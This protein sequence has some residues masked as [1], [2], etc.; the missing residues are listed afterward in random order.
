MTL[1]ELLNLLANNSDKIDVLWNFFIW[2]HLAVLGGLVLSNRPLTLLE[3]LIA[4]VAY[5]AFSFVNYHALQDTY[6]YH[7][8]LLAEIAGLKV[9]AATLGAQTVAYLRD[10]NMAGR[11]ALIMQYGHLAAGAVV[12][13]A[14]LSANL[15]T[16]ARR[17]TV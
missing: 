15:I 5:A 2:I 14:L 8:V 7:A 11:I 1:Y 17:N 6:D 4:I 13:I 10:W 12:T 9:D 16:G 3:R